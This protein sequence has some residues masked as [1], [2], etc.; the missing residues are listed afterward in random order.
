MKFRDYLNEGESFDS[1][2]KGIKTDYQKKWVDEIL[3]DKETISMAKG[4]GMDLNDPDDAKRVIT[5]ILTSIKSKTVKGTRV[6]TLDLKIGSK[7]FKFKEEE[8]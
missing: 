4:L 3:S 1:R 6:H 7:T 2:H 5:N 8:N